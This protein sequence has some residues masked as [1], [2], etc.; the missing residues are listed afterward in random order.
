MS[1]FDFSV[2]YLFQNQIQFYWNKYRNRFP[3]GSRKEVSGAVTLFPF[4]R[5]SVQQVS[6]V[7]KSDNKQLHSYFAIILYNCIR[8]F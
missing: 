3:G 1:T 8:L 5:H 2:K 6:E 4:P 7:M